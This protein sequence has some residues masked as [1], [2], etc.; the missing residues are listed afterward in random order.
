MKSVMRFLSFSKLL[1]HVRWMKRLIINRKE[2][3]NRCWSTSQ[4][5]VSV[6]VFQRKIQCDGL[7]LIIAC[8][9][10]IHWFGEPCGMYTALVRDLRVKVVCCR[11]NYLSCR[12][13]SLWNGVMIFVSTSWHHKWNVANGTVLIFIFIRW[14]NGW[15]QVLQWMHI[16]KGLSCG[17]KT[18][19]VTWI[20]IMCRFISLSRNSFMTFLIGMVRTISAILPSEF[21]A[22]ILIGRNCFVVGFL[23]W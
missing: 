4:D 2:T 3:N 7:V 1:L 23:V 22:I 12:W 15:W 19:Y 16:M 10:T 17:I 21:L 8:R 5:I 9:R 11:N 14:I 20:R 13:M 18:W 6:P